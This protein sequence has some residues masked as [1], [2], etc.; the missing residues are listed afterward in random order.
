MIKGLGDVIDRAEFHGIDGRAQAG[1][2]GHD[3]NG[4]FT[5]KFNEV[6]AVATGQS[7]VAD[8]HVVAGQ[9]ERF[10]SVDGVCFG[11]FMVMAS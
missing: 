7:Q 4:H 5:G 3:Q 9:V 1:V 10:C 11:H 2:A 8:D 6:C